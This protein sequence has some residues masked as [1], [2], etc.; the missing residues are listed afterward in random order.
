MAAYATLQTLITVTG[1]TSSGDVIEIQPMEGWI[2]MLNY[3]SAV[4][5]V[6]TKSVSLA[7]GDTADIAL[8]TLDSKRGGSLEAVPSGP[9]WDVWTETGISSNQWYKKAI[10]LEQATYPI[11]R[12]LCWVLTVNQGGSPG[13]FSATFEIFVTA[14]VV[15]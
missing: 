5:T 10:T 14:K 15:A 6:H 1:D 2:D 3:A 12:W 8:S 7:S 11:D 9:R 4:I 13:A